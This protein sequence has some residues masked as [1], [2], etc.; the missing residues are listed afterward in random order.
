M[1]KLLN[2]VHFSVLIFNQ[3]AV[4][5]IA[6]YVNVEIENDFLRIGCLSILKTFITKPNHTTVLGLGD[7]FHL[8]KSSALSKNRFQFL[9]ELFVTGVS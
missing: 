6:S 5:L 1:S 4:D 8:K 7:W 3:K 9:F 2:I